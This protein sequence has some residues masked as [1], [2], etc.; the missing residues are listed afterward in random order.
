ML[1]SE[2]IN[3]GTSDQLVKKAANSR[4]YVGI[5]NLGSANDVHIAFG[6]QAATALNGI[7]IGP[8]EYFDTHA[9]FNGSEVRGIAITAAVDIVFVS[10]N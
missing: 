4:A 5:Q 3:V 9:P 6:G 7:R 8:G 10:D 2:A 1:V